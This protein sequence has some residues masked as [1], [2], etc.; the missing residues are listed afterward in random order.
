MAIDWNLA[1]PAPIMAQAKPFDLGGVLKQQA[2]TGLANAQADYTAVKSAGD[3]LDNTL[4]MA[5]MVASTLNPINMEQDPAKQAQMWS[6]LVPSLK[7]MGVDPVKFGISEEWNED[8]QKKLL[9]LGTMAT[10][11][12][13]TKRGNVS[14][15][16]Q[17]YEKGKADPGFLDYQRRQKVENKLEVVEGTESA[18]TKEK[19]DRDFIKPIVESA[20]TQEPVVADLKLLR[21]YVKHVQLGKFS[22]A[23]KL[24]AQIGG[25]LGHK[26]SEVEASKLETINGLVT[27]QVIQ[28][29]KML[30]PVTETDIEELKKGIGG[31]GLTNE[32]TL[33][34]LNT[35]IATGERAVN[36][37]EFVLRYKGL[38]NTTAGA[39]IKYQELLK[40][41]P[42]RK[43]NEDGTIEYLEQSNLH[44]KFDKYSTKP[45]YTEDVD[46]T[47][48]T[49]QPI[50][51]ATQKPINSTPT[52]IGPDGRHISQEELDIKAK[53]YK[54]DRESLIK[55]WQLTPSAEKK[56]LSF[57]P[58]N[59][60]LSASTNPTT[61]PINIKPTTTHMD[62]AKSYLGTNEVKDNK[63]LAGFFKQALGQ[64]IDPA[65]VPWCAAFANSVLKQVGLPGTGSLMARSFLNIGEAT[66]SPEVGDIVVLSRGNNA[67]SGH[68]GFYAG[69]DEAGRIK[70]LGGNQNDTVT[71]SSFPTSQ[72]LGYR[73]P[74]KADELH[75]ALD[76]GQV[77]TGITLNNP[78]N[79]MKS[80]KQ[81]AGEVESDHKRLRAFQSPEDGLNA[82][83]DVVDGYSKKG[84]NSVASIITKYAPPNENLTAN[85]I[86]FV[87]NKL[88]VKATQKLDLSNPTI[89]RDLIDAIITL[90]QGS[91]PYKHILYA[92]V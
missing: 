71:V 20:A 22:E 80:S 53:Q 16:I 56:S 49:Q 76:N 66:K 59:Q 39:D 27:Q 44:S 68:V 46:V 84:L 1:D 72:V 23:R 6:E 62:I 65:K 60:P 79:L 25:E 5:N 38:N 91:N 61:V 26:L 64:N 24:A 13:T 7:K 87:A 21:D 14:T 52:F 19:A 12:L 67:N 17:N 11:A 8:T 42:I 88:N 48:T 82:M 29:A 50:N 75:H 10:N 85:Y 35:A 43:V 69:K 40:D 36:K 77:T 81:F 73:K 15:D 55:H 89:K 83:S 2:D 63:A 78:G 18:K 54:T 74:P 30:S 9:V 70:V 57:E 37:R 51:P 90:E 33:N 34:L 47:A 41:N 4:Q 3:K 58:N 28:K 31:A 86:R 45:N 92:G 32:G